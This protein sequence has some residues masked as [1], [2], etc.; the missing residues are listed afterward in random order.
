MKVILI[1]AKKLGQIFAIGVFSHADITDLCK[2][3][4]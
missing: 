2:G 4:V 1:D 3:A